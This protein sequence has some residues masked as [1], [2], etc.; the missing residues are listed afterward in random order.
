M[1][2]LLRKRRPSPGTVLGLL[3]L[4]AALGGTA[5]AGP[6]AHDSALTKKEKKQIRKIARGEITK[7]APTLSVASAAAAGQVDGHDAVCPAATVLRNGI[8]FETAGRGNSDWTGA[9][10]TCADAGGFLPTPSELLSIRNVTGI[11]LGG[12]GDGSWADARYQNDDNTNEAMTVLDNGTLEGVALAGPRDF[13]CA[14]T[15]VR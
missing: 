1:K 15:L 6:L 10:Q 12:T 13:R 7:A 11:D 2:D 4:I 9:V 14:F 5:I 8:C 3:A